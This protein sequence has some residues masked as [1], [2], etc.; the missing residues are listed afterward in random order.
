M[1]FDEVLK[2]KEYLKQYNKAVH[3]HDSCGGQY[4]TLEEK[5]EELEK[6]IRGYFEEKNQA[7]LFDESGIQFVVK[8][9]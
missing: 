6:L 5:D 9:K 4:F 8:E 3:F 2:L 1:I 7:V